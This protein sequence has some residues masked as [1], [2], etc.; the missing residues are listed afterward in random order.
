MMD[1]MNNDL[2]EEEFLSVLIL[3]SVTKFPLFE[4][5]FFNL[6]SRIAFAI[7][8]EK[9]PKMNPTRVAGSV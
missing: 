4:I 7:A 9:P 2:L 3:P 5:L 8:Y 1:P 6:L